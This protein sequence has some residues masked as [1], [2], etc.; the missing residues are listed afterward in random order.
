MLCQQ[1]EEFLAKSNKRNKLISLIQWEP[2]CKK[3]AKIRGNGNKI[4]IKIILS[5]EI[6]NIHPFN[7]TT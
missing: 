3:I 2:G 7:L 6:V 5:A 4:L 1:E